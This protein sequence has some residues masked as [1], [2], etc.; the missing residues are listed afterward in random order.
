MKSSLKKLSFAIATVAMLSGTNADATIRR[1]G[2]N[3]VLV[4]GVD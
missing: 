3:G 1:V 2:Y 4:T